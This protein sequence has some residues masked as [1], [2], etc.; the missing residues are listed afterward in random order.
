ME[1]NIVQIMENGARG[2][3]VRG[4]TEIGIQDRLQVDE[5][6]LLEEITHRINNDLTSTIKF[7]G[8]NGGTFG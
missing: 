3:G 6:I 8:I 5:T 2:T 1:G 7:I 4:F